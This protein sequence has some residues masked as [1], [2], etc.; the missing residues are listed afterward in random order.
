MGVMQSI[1]L[2]YQ[3]YPQ[4]AK[5]PHRPGD[6]PLKTADRTLMSHAGFEVVAREEDV[7][8]V[9]VAPTPNPT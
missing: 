9:P 1:K 3:D 6:A 4:G 5:V 7:L 8:D 2:P